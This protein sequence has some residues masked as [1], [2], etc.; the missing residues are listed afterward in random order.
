MLP[1][2]RLHD[3]SI[4]AELCSNLD[5]MT[6][7]VNSCGNFGNKVPTYWEIKHHFRCYFQ[8]KLH[9]NNQCERERSF[10]WGWKTTLENVENVS[11]P[12]W[13]NLPR[14]SKKW[15]IWLLNEFVFLHR[16]QKD[17]TTGSWSA[18]TRPH[19]EWL[20]RVYS[21][22]SKGTKLLCKGFFVEGG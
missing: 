17:L 18:K 2:T 20:M 9:R 5:L 16:P 8:G 6:S 10:A 11:K 13:G 12:K 22:Q 14:I 4:T 19:R 7:T 15:N 3:S 21:F 1:S